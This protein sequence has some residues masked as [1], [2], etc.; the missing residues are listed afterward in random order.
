MADCVIR[1]KAYITLTLLSNHRFHKAVKE[2]PISQTARYF[3]ALRD[4]ICV[5]FQ[6]YIINLCLCVRSVWEVSDLAWFVVCSR[7]TS[8]FNFSDIIFVFLTC[9]FAIRNVRFITLSREKEI[10]QLA[11][12][13]Q[14]IL[15][16][17]PESEGMIPFIF[18][19]AQNVLVVWWWARLFGRN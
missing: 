10:A 11:K 6:T 1:L 19:S 7:L 5:I 16:S 15:Q 9:S 4:L 18:Y 8:R 14:P 17:F 12:R 2:P 3:F 13:K